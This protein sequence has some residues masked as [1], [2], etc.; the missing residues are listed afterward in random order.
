MTIKN[1]KQS[2]PPSFPPDELPKGSSIK[3]VELEMPVILALRAL[4]TEDRSKFMRGSQDNFRKIRKLAGWEK[5]QLADSLMILLAKLN[6]EIYRKELEA[7]NHLLTNPESIFNINVLSFKDRQEVLD[8]NIY[9]IFKEKFLDSENPFPELTCSKGLMQI[10]VKYNGLLLGSVDPSLYEDLDIIREA[11]NQNGLALQFVSHSIQDTHPDIV[12]MAIDQAPDS[13]A[14]ASPAMQNN[15]EIL[16]ALAARDGFTAL[17]LI[18][19]DVQNQYP[20][21]VKIA[22]R[23]NL[24]AYEA[25]T[26]EKR[27]NIRNAFTVA[28][29]D[30]KNNIEFLRE[31]VTENGMALRIIPPAIQNQYPD[32][33]EKAVEQNGLAIV[34]APLHLRHS[35]RLLEKAITQNGLALEYA[36][37]PMKNKEVFVRKA[38]AQNGLAL[39]YAAGWLRGDLETIKIAITQNKEAIRFISYDELAQDPEIQEILNR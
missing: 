5:K 14:F 32:L 11:V 3:K 17:Q 9:R 31:L 22:L 34:H 7:I 2:L 28:S 36:P 33:V 38:V 27:R 12:K 37:I 25:A 26:V 35:L 23:Q 20:E 6:P 16:K 21:I 39:Q 30:I 24:N 19:K 4:S 15:L 18:P 8:E 29:P 10:A 1:V 13:F